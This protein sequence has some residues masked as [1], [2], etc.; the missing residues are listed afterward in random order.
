MR[1]GGTQVWNQPMHS[2]WTPLDWA[3]VNFFLLFLSTCCERWRWQN[4][5]TRVVVL[6]STSGVIEHGL[7][8]KLLQK[9]HFV[10]EKIWKTGW[11][12]Q[13]LWKIWV[14]QF[15]WLFPIYGKNKN[16]PNHQPENSINRGC[17]NSP[18]LITGKSS[19]VGSNML[20]HTIE[21]HNIRDMWD[22]KDL[23]G[24]AWTNGIEIKVGSSTFNS[25]WDNHTKWGPLDS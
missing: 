14:R 6:G 8:G 20:S 25:V 1:F 21:N 16:V 11:W 24:I 7:L 2:V 23:K 3:C 5:G 22:M 17:C 10:Y 18:C 4:Y 9:L 13:H 12:F 19:G 15:G